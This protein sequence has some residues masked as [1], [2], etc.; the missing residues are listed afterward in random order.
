MTPYSATP[1]DWIFVKDYGFLFL[2]KNIIKNIGK[3]ISKNLR[4]KYSEKRIDHAKNSAT[5]NCFRKT[6]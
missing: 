1:E 5:E 6:I 2:A 4:G 3:S